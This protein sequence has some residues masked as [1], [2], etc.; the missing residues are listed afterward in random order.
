MISLSKLASIYQLIEATSQSF[1]AMHQDALTTE[2][3]ITSNY[4][5]MEN[6]RTQNDEVLQV[7]TAIVSSMQSLQQSTAQAQKMTSMIQGIASQ[8]NLLALNA[9]IEAARAGDY[10]KGFAVV[11]EEIRK[12]SDQSRDA[13]EEIQA[14]MSVVSSESAQNV[15]QVQTGQTAILHSNDTVQRFTQDFKNI[16]TM[17]DQLLHYIFNMKEKVAT[18]R[19]DAGEVAATIE[20]VRTVSDNGV[21]AVKD[22]QSMSQ[23]QTGSSHIVNAEIAE[24]NDLAQSLE[25]QF[26]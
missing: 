18:I 15:K 26:T 1:E 14:I 25:R 12:L 2:Q 11:A 6:I 9:S 22:L 20:Q 7:V 16:H 8:T 19:T 13:A 24:L 3:A 10:G 17:I 4:E 23:R 21:D 5:M